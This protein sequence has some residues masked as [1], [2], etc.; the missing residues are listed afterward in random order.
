[1]TQTARIDGTAIRRSRRKAHL[2]QAQLAEAAGCARNT[3][4]RAECGD[5]SERLAERIAAAV[6]VDPNTLYAQNTPSN[7]PLPLT[8][9]QEAVVAI[10]RRGP[11]VSRAIWHFALGAAAMADTPA[12]PAD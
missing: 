10:M 4:S 5:C 12:S 6:R 3:I 11:S 8:S 1:M 2:T 9:E 7:A